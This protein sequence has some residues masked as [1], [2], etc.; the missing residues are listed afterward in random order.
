MFLLLRLIGLSKATEIFIFGKSV[1]EYE[2][3]RIGL[4][5][6]CVSN[7]KFEQEVWGL[8]KQ[9]LRGNN[10]NTDVISRRSII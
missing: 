5:N 2:A 6:K 4:A 8:A 7:E 9:F 3:E 10:K 1:D